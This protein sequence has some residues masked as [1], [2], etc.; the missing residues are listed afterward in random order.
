MAR[1]LPYGS[2]PSPISAADAAAGSTR[3]DG[4]RFVNG[5]AY[6]VQSVA[7]RMTVFREGASEPLLPEP[8]NVRSRVHMYGGGAWSAG[9][10]GTVFFVEAS[11]QRVWSL[12]PGSAE[13]RPLT[14]VDETATYGGLTISAGV[15]LAV[16]ERRVTTGIERDI[17]TIATRG[18][19]DDDDAVMSLASGTDFVAQPA[20]SPDA[21]SLSW[22]G[23]NHPNMPW[24]H[25]DV[26]VRSLVAQNHP[27][28]VSDGAGL[29]P[30]WSNRGDLFFADDRSGR[31][32]LRAVPAGSASSL[33]VAPSD[34][35]TGGAL[36]VLG[37]SWFRL[38]D[39][40]RVLAVRTDGRDRL[41][42]IS[43][44][45]EREIETPL[46]AGLMVEDVD[47]TR[48]LVSGAGEQVPGGVWLLDV[49]DPTI[50]R[51]VAG[52]VA[53][54]GSEWLPHAES[55]TLDGPHG[56]IH[57]FY[58][59]PTNPNTSAV[60]GELPPVLMMVHGGPTD[61]TSPALSP[62]I[63]YFTSRGI[64]V[65]EVNYGG[66]TGYG[67]A[68]RERLRG[69]WGVVDVDDVI[70]AADALAA[71]G[72]V[73]PDRI[74]VRGGSAGGWT[75]LNALA[76][77]NRFAAGI[78]RYPVTDARALASNDGEFESRYFDGLIGPLPEANDLYVARSP[79]THAAHI[80]SPVLLEQGDD[81]PVVPQSQA[82]LIRD[83]LVANGVP[84]AYVLFAGEGHGFRK[85]ETLV[86]SLETELG[87]LGAVFGFDAGVPALVLS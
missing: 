52:G 12:A 40:G 60:P 19:A 63:T 76:R 85:P 7:G 5:A 80:A 17:V 6:W 11:D 10:D 23:W 69:Q 29:Q 67:R 58:Y 62:T 33:P 16:R 56:D 83:A 43:P 64:A 61:H 70:A 78:A 27:F 71:S 30:Q 9:A 66:S 25:A 35:D 51:P 38:L 46:S 36:W 22:V 4:A 34:A 8:W 15:L 68:Y 49:D 84:H 2:W 86:R 32:N 21:A 57:A 20:L 18:G 53:A 28:A 81:D 87:L 72:R 37:L 59:A 79:L 73:D 42:L 82:E 41:V 65:C 47:G 55:M 44:D 14:P 24:D 48:A 1:S 13:P 77:S 45:G 74:A 39:D 54:W 50:L 26:F 3:F 31:W 75:V